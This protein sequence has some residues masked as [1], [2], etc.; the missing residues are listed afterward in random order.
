MRLFEMLV[1]IIKIIWILS[2]I[3]LWQLHAAPTECRAEVIGVHS[4]STKLSFPKIIAGFKAREGREKVLIEK[5]RK[6]GGSSSKKDF[7]T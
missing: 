2:N 6:V 4:L 3:W 7:L 5:R 1:F